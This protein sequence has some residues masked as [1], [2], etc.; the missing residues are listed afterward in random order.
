M[1]AP[2]VKSIANRLRK[3][4]NS[5]QPFVKNLY[6]GIASYYVFPNVGANKRVVLDESSERRKTERRD[7]CPLHGKK[8]LKDK[9]EAADAV[10]QIFLKVLTHFPK[11]EIKNFKGWLYVMLRNHCLQIL[12]N[13]YHK[14]PDELLNNLPANYEGEKEQQN[15]EYSLE[16]MNEAMK[17]LNEEQR[18]TISLFYLQRLSYQQIMEQTGFSFMQVKSF[19]QNGK[20]N[21]KLILNKKLSNPH[22]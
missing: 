13:Q 4:M 8:Y 14:L 22:E 9:D 11:D 3:V 21:L 5:K 19:I 20:R 10:Q 6:S 7:D 1:F 17:E 15:K 12:R 2:S 18:I 16:Q